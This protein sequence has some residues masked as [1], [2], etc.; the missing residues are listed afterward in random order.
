MSVLVPYDG[1][2]PAQKAIE[3]AIEHDPDREIVLLRVVEVATGS[4]DAGIGAVQDRLKELRDESTADVADEVVDL[5]DDA[6]VEYR[7][8]TVAGK[9]AREIVDY[10]ETHDV[11]EIVIGSHGRQGVS[12]V[13]LGS[14][15][16]DVVRR[17]PTTVTVVR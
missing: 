10:S 1:S 13:L 6:D 7:V 9:P 15:A 16:E 4:I 17:A 14:V 8:E 5:L 3:R 2:L 11:D 12:R